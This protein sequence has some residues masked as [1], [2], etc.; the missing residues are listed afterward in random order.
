MEVRTQCTF[1]S[2]E[3]SKRREVEHL[4]EFNAQAWQDRLSDAERR[5]HSAE[6][7]VAVLRSLELELNLN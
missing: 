2:R 3:A 1:G 7:S 5:A 6:K 4:D